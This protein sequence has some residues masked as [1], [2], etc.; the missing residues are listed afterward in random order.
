M[1]SI[2]EVAHDADLGGR[3]AVRLLGSDVD[4]RALTRLFYGTIGVAAAL[5]FALV[6]YWSLRLNSSIGSIIQNT[7]GTPLYFWPY[8]IL[9]VAAIVLFGVNAILLVYRWRIWGPPRLRAQG[10]SGLGSVVGVAASACPVCG[11]AL[12]AAVGISGGLAAFPLQGLELKALS[13]GLLAFPVWLTARDLRRPP[14]LP[15][16]GCPVPRD[17]AFRERDR[18]WLLGLLALV[19]VLAVVGRNMLKD[20]PAVARL[21]TATRA[22][23]A[24]IL[25]PGDNQL[26]DANA[27]AANPLFDEMT[28]QVLPEAGFQSTIHLGDSVPKLVAEGVIDR[29]K[30]EALYQDRGGLPEELRSVLSE[31]SGRPILLTRQNANYYVNLLW[32]LGL[33]NFMTT[34]RESPL[35]GDRL[36]NFASTGGWDLGKEDNGGAYFNKFTIVPLT[37][38]QE[39]L[40]TRIAQNAYRPCCNNPTFFQDCN[41]GS[42]LLGL[43]QLG[44]SQGLSEDELYREALAFNAFWFPHNYLQTALYFKAVKDTDWGEVDPKVVLGKDYSTISGWSETVNKEVTRLGLVPQAQAGGGCS[45]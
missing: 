8:T 16:G 31:P 37:P 40:V 4:R 34:N 25:N 44:A 41:H 15:S 5:A 7:A 43:L 29:G 28:K 27:A 18:P 45:V 22:Q 12:L 33:A 2:P 38:D 39:A 26:Q 30:F 20:D 23:G 42:A 10:G 11:S 9:T 21:F 19:A 35:A 3:V 6:L 1:A 17:P 14:C 13:V 32:P 24:T 36:F